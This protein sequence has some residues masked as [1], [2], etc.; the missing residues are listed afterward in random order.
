MGV[1]ISAGAGM[2]HAQG[3][4]TYMAPVVDEKT[5]TALARVVL[6][7]PDGRLRPGLFV[8]AEIAIGQESAAVVIPKSAVQRMDEESVVFLDKAE[9]F[10]PALVSLGRSN[11][12][13]VEVLS[14]LAAGQRYV[15]KGAFE[16]KAKIVTSGLDAHAGHGH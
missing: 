7:N 11:Q 13:H 10:T 4:I 15:T 12:S 2:P 6:P 5:R 16:L 14:G 8:S 1:A 9:G 3:T